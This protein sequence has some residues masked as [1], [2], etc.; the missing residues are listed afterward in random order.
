MIKDS[1]RVS[2]LHGLA[3]M[4]RQLYT[5]RQAKAA[6]I[7]LERVP[8]AD[9]EQ[10]LGESSAFLGARVRYAIEDAL[11]HRKA[12]ADDNAQGTLR[13]IAAVLNAWLH[14]GRRLA[15]RAVL[16]ELSADELAELAA[17]PDIHDEVASMTSDFTG[18]IAP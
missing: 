8:R 13:A 4:L 10:L 1:A 11:R 6:D 5:A 17:L 15:I 12:A 14:D 7:L 3:E 18:G 16:R 9:L 2:S